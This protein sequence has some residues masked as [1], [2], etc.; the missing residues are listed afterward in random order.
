MAEFMIVCTFLDGTDMA[1]VFGGVAEEQ[2][3][4]A[5]LVAE[6]RIG[7]VQLA[8][9]RGTVFLQVFAEDEHE[10]AATVR[11]LPMATWWDIDA[12]PIAAPV[13]QGDR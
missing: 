5:A 7:T 4:V 3:A 8:L 6:G 2:A 13:I 9:A 10:A 12:F 1:E 11:S